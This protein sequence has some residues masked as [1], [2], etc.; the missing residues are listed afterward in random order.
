M[1]IDVSPA[2]RGEVR[3]IDFG[4][5]ADAPENPPDVTF[6]GRVRIRGTFTDQS[7]YMAVK[8]TA[9]LPYS[10][11][12]ARCFREI[13]GVFTLNFEKPAAVS[14]TLS[15]RQDAEDYILIQK[16]TID[17]DPMVSEALTLEFPMVFLC[18]EDCKGLCP[19][20]GKDLN[21]GECGCPKKEID[22]RLAILGKL[23]DK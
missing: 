1:E 21:D 22:S 4:Y 2:L 12:C 18:K 10:T 23:L 8:L 9:D 16:G 6:T 13:S 17:P 20:C 3:R 19:K 5:D 14:G 7:G 15:D 11:H